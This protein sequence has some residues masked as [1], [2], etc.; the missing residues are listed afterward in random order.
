MN[1]NLPRK[2]LFF[3]REDHISRSVTIDGVVYWLA[4]DW[5]TTGYLIISFDITTEEFGEVNLPYSLARTEHFLKFSKLRESLVVIE[6]VVCD[7]LVY[8]L[9][10]ME[11]GVPK[12][13]TK[14]STFDVN[15]HYD[16]LIVGFTQR[17]D[18]IIRLTDGQLVVYEPHSRQM[19]NLGF[20]GAGRVVFGQPYTETL[21][22]HDQPYLTDDTEVVQE[23]LASLQIGYSL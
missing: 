1:L 17:G 22:L 4:T 21:F 15:T 14:I 5:S 13:F 10:M 9:W 8:N 7:R 6:N 11:D 2:S 18:P 12:S 20:D 3:T 16:A 19:D 23:K